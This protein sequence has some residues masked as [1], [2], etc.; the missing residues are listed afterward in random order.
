MIFI[1]E[2]RSKKK[3]KTN[4]HICH[5]HKWTKGVNPRAITYWPI[6]ELEPECHIKLLREPPRVSRN[7]VPTLAKK[8]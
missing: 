8:S 1:T 3:D 2:D 4:Y 6:K 7:S 5:T